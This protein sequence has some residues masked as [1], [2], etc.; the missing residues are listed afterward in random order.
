MKPGDCNPNSQST[1]SEYDSWFCAKVEE[2]L[3][4]RRPTTPHGVVDAY[5]RKRRAAAGSRLMRLERDDKNHNEKKCDSEASADDGNPTENLKDSSDEEEKFAA[6]CRGKE[7]D[8]ILGVK[9]QKPA[10]AYRP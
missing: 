9:R 4:D 1:S 10:K 8:R 7:S 5:F 6:L 2:G 3:V